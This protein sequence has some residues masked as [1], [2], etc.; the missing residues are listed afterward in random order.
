MAT[1][2]AQHRSQGPPVVRVAI[3][4]VSDTRTL[5]ND[6]SGDRI[7]ELCEL[8]GHRVVDR[9]VVV[10]A[11]DPIRGWVERT[12]D[13]GEAQAALITGGTGISP[14]DVTVEAIEPMLTRS[15]PGFGE[16]FRMLS[17][18]EIGSAAIMSR[19]TA[20]LVGSMILVTLPGSRAGVDLAMNRIIIPELP[21]LVGQAQKT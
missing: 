2:V 16:L 21:H 13:A 5:A 7:R 20:G 6:L 1:V 10:D 18:A 9:Q 15:I 19:A 11:V 14:R 4:T 8:A 12:R 3:L 17:Y